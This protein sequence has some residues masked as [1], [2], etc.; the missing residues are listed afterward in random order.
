MSIIKAP[1]FKY[2]KNF[3][4]GIGAAL[5]MLGALGKI[6][7]EPWGGT[8]IT[9]GLLTEAFI[10]CLLGI[11]PPEKDYYWEKLYPG[12]DKYNARISPLTEG[13]APDSMR[14]LNGEFVEGQLGGMLTE[15][16]TMS[17]SMSSLKAL[18]EVDFSQTSDQIKS[19]GN[20][21]ERMN[22]AMVVLSETVEDTKVYR[23]QLASL[24]ENINNVNL[25]YQS[26]AESRQHVER[27]NESMRVLGDTVED[28]ST[29]KSQMSNLNNNLAGLNNVYGNVLSA[30]TGKG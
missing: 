26:V 21:Y 27:L 14:P 17:K 20:F 22:D 13:E 1:W 30:M 8:A 15:L 11:I 2:A 12:L 6:N 9:I 28:V 19:M 23:S 10:F 29:Y 7:S 24:N 5:V 16:Q 4:I 18:Q 3:I 25:V